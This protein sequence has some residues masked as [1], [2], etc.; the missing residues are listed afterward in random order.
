LRLRGCLDLSCDSHS[1]LLSG[2]GG[3]LRLFHKI[4]KRCVRFS[5]KCLF[6]SSSLVRSV[7]LHNIFD[8]GCMSISKNIMHHACMLLGLNFDSLLNGNVSVGD[9]RLF[10]VNVCDQE[11]T[12]TYSVR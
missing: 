4:S 6:G 10:K 3:T 11:C 7:V 2:L 1:F 9:R 12:V 8:T 5:Y